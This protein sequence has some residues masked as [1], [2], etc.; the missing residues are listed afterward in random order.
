MNIKFVYGQTYNSIKSF[1]AQRKIIENVYTLTQ[2]N[3]GYIWIAT[4]NGVLK[5]NGNTFVKFDLNSGLPSNDIFNI[6]IDTKNRVWLSGYFSGLYY[7][8]NNIVYKIKKSNEIKG[9]VRFFENKDTLFINPLYKLKTYYLSKNNLTLKRKNSLFEYVN[10]NRIK[11]QYD[12]EDVIIRENNSK[13]SKLSKVQVVNFLMKN[14]FAYYDTQSSNYNPFYRFIPNKFKVYNNQNYFIID[15]SL[16]SNYNFKIISR[17][18]D[19]FLILLNNQN[20]VLV[21]YNG[22]FNKKITDYINSLPINLKDINKL[23]IDKKFNVWVIS[24]NLELTFIPEN[25]RDILNFNFNFKIKKVTSSSDAFYLLS[26]NKIFIYNIKKKSIIDTVKFNYE[27]KD[28]K[29]IKK[30][31]FYFYN[32]GE[33]YYSDLNN[34]KKKFKF[35]LKGLK[36]LLYFKEDYYCIIGRGLFSLKKGKIFSN[37]NSIRF[38]DFFSFNDGFV[39]SNEEELIYYNLLKKQTLKKNIKFINS[40]VKINDYNLIVASNE[41]KIQ[42]LDKDLKIKSNFFINENIIKLFYNKKNNK[43]L[44]YTYGGLYVFNLNSHNKIVLDKI[45][46]IE[47]G[48]IEGKIVDLILIDDITYLFTNKGF[49]KVEKSFYNDEIYDDAKIDILNINSKIKDKLV[50]NF[51]LDRNDNDLNI[52]LSIKS[53]NNLK[54]YKIFYKINDTNWV[55]LKNNELTFNNLMPNLYKLELK[56]SN[57]NINTPIDY[58]S[59]IFKV[60]PYFWETFLFKILIIFLLIIS[61]FF[62]SFYFV[63]LN[64]KKNKLKL[65]LTN[66]EMKSLRA[67]MNPHFIFNSINN[68]QSYIFLKDELSV[69][70]YILKFS[71]LLRATLENVNNDFSTLKDEVLY[72]NKCI[73]FE[74]LKRNILIEF[75]VINKID[76]DNILIPNMILQPIIENSIVHGFKNNNNFFI[77][78]QINTDENYLFI[79][80]IDNG[81]GLLIENE[82]SNKK[83]YGISIIKERL[84]IMSKIDSL[85]YKY[86]ID[87]LLD[88]NKNIKGTKVLLKLP[89]MKKNNKY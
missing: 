33:V 82:K 38:N 84:I 83:S 17:I 3:N 34:L 79:E 80:I 41:G 28:I 59:I 43:I 36:T 22:I 48:L 69:N 65:K 42:I 57:N 2:D 60:K 50:N 72:L 16:D 18:D 56:I 8:Q 11:L 49:S 6:Y 26:E 46:T 76:L 89:L 61:T 27:I 73:E 32:N 14:S 1:S 70:N 62:I 64:R 21:Y 20:K 45:L 85:D 55:L 23:F 53:F 47:N 44:V 10:G 88:E 40:I 63:N 71:N 77:K 66:L 24:E 86:E 78:L 13:K 74:S 29:I 35:E 30:R 37:E 58:K 9:L 39:L 75:I 54:K 52:N 31:L 68:L 67:Q 4:D 51:I 19:K 81:I 7:V 87:N 25:Y 15:P 5:F 12:K